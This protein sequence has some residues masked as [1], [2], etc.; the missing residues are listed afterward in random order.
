MSQKKLV[1]GADWTQLDTGIGKKRDA[2]SIFK[3]NA[4]ELSASYV[5]KKRLNE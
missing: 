1:A 5:N 3:D 2:A 4:A